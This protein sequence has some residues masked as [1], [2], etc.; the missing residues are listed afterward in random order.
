MQSRPRSTIRLADRYHVV[1][2][3][4]AAFRNETDIGKLSRACALSGIQIDIT[5][6]IPPGLTLMHI[7][8]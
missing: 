3:R 8:A 2:I 7:K 1:I 5:P 6:P 4:S